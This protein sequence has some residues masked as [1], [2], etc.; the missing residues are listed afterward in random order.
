MISHECYRLIRE[1]KLSSA[2]NNRLEQKSLKPEFLTLHKGGQQKQRRQ[3]SKATREKS[4]M[5]RMESCPDPGRDHHCPHAFMLF[6]L[7]IFS[8]GI[9]PC[10]NLILLACLDS[11]SVPCVISSHKQLLCFIGRAIWTGAET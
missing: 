9:P 7:Y 3:D 1:K 11:I 10:Y 5:L 4:D 8:S 2:R 6:F